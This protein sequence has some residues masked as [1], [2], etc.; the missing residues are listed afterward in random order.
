MMQKFYSLAVIFLLG[1]YATTC[2][3]HSERISVRSFKDGDVLF[4]DS[5]SSQSEDIKAIT[6]SSFCH[7]GV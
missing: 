5:R 3:V 1:G 6:H 7:V 2:S 4:Q